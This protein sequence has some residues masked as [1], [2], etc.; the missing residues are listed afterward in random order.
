MHHIQARYSR[1]YWHF[2]SCCCVYFEMRSG[3]IISV[4]FKARTVTIFINCCNFFFLLSTSILLQIRVKENSGA[5]LFQEFATK[6]LKHLYIY[7]YTIYLYTKT[8]IHY[9]KRTILQRDLKFCWH[10]SENNF[11]GPSKSFC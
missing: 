8:Y 7:I 9:V 2:C 5:C 6:N 1:K 10:R 11:V 3:F 4:L